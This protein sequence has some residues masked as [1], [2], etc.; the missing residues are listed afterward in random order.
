VFQRKTQTEGYWRDQF[1]LTAPDVARIYDLILDSGKPVRPWVL[2]RALI[3]AG[4]RREEAAIQ[5]EL[6]RGVPYRPSG[7]YSVGQEITFPALDYSWATV[8]GT[9]P[10]RNPQYGEFVALQ[11]RFEGEEQI[12][13]FASELRGD[14]KLDQEASDS[15]PLASG[16][17]RS[18]EELA[19]LYGGVVAETIASGLAGHAEFVRLGDDWFLGELLADVS[20]GHLNI[21]EALIEVKGMP[22]PTAELMADLDLP[23]EVPEE[24]RALS[25]KRALKLD[26]RFDNVGNGGRDVWF[27]RRLTPG[28]VLQ[29]PSR[30]V[31]RPDAYDRQLISRE[32]QSLEREIDD[33]GVSEPDAA[34]PRPIYR[35]SVTLNH[36]HWRSGT[37][38]LTLRTRGMFPQPTEHHTPFVLVDGQ[39]G[40]R[41]QGWVV[42]QPPFVYGLREYYQK[43]ALPVGAFVK[44]ERTRD[45]RVITVDYEPQRLKSAWAK[46]VSARPGQLSFQVRKIPVACEYDEQMILAEDSAP[47]IDSLREEHEA[48]GTSLLELMIRIIQEL[49]KL[50]PQGTVHAKTVYSAVNVLRR[51]APGPIFALLSTESCFASMGG[52]YWTF[53]ASRIRPDV[54]AQGG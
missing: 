26:G 45:P 27:L 32:L 42:Q 34:P 23:L 2:A 40:D 7:T 10:A 50:S 18:P 47:G 16:G 21:A 9:R 4:C 6:S 39:S 24:I 17:A 52:G 19:E 11:V 12:R 28:E 31:L 15:S 14:H 48:R 46:V 25:L 41:F 37:L 3:D 20:I 29:P 51:T 38:P 35:T 5:A 33:E 1:R 44:L 54:V 53:D 43:H 22:L 8:T 30:L 36:P 49:V 13:E